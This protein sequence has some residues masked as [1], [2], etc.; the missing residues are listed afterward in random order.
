MGSMTN[1]LENKLLDHSLGK[2]SFT[3]PTVTYVA[4]FTADPTET[5]SLANEQSGTGYA[6][7]QITAANWNAA[8]GGATDN[9]AAVTFTAS[10]N[11]TNACTHMGIADSA[12]AG[13]GNLLFYDDITSTTLNNG[14]SLTFAIGAI[15]ITLD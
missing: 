7:Q 10:A 15:D 4:L 12:T 11:W 13:A 8:S 14:D 6:R 3:M 2:T 1:Y 9:A 5:G